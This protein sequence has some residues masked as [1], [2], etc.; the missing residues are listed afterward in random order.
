MATADPIME[1]NYEIDSESCKKQD[2]NCTFRECSVCLKEIEQVLLYQLDD[3]PG[4]LSIVQIRPL[5]I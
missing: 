4:L 5:I 3:I 1:D 2:S